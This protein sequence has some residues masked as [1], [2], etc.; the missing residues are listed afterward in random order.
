[1]GDGVT[2]AMPSPTDLPS[3]L[4]FHHIG[5]ACR[6]LDAEERAYARLG[7]TREGADFQD[8]I[9]GIGGRFLTGAGP[10]LELLI[11]LPGSGVLTPWLRKGIR[12]YHLAWEAENL[13]EASAS[14]QATRARVVVDPVP[15]VA[16][17]GREITFLMLPNLQ[18][19]EL[20]SR[21]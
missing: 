6:N 4:L 5:V 20:I 9:Q 14:L 7:Y 13:R 21:W 8:P 2:A 16:F 15:A 1:L 11:E 18:L 17:G 19:I 10:R 3:G 12:L